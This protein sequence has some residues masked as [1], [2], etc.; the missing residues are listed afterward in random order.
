[1]LHSDACARSCSTRPSHKTNLRLE[2]PILVH[3]IVQTLESHPSS[4]PMATNLQQHCFTDL[5][6]P[7][8]STHHR[9]APGYTF[10]L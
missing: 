3:K 5:E 6:P 9:P 7:P 4:F 2:A 8:L 1:V 10:S